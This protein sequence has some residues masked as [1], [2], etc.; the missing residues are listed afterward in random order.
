MQSSFKIRTLTKKGPGHGGRATACAN[1]SVGSRR[2]IKP[3]LLGKVT[4]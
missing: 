1:A 3:N 4:L 2:H